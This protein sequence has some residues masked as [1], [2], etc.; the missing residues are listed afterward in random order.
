MVTGQDAGGGNGGE[1]GGKAPKEAA[2][3]K[4]SENEN[5][6]S[7][8]RVVRI[9]RLLQ[10]M[11]EGH[12]RP[13]Q[14]HLREQKLND[15]SINPRSFDFIAFISTMLGVFQKQYLN[16]YSHELGSQMIDTLVEVI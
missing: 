13:L 8:I 1:E 7:L 3:S 12:F 5:Q 6:K 10:L 4:S 9:L 11:A 15:G 2:D 14:D 16:C